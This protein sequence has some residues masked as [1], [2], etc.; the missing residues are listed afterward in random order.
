MVLK[1]YKRDEV[2]LNYLKKQNPNHWQFICKWRKNKSIP[3]NKKPSCR[4][5]T[6]CELLWKKYCEHFR[7]IFSRLKTYYFKVEIEIDKESC[8]KFEQQKT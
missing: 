1:G 7:V 6:Y 5:D 8:A 4:C 2:N 3:K